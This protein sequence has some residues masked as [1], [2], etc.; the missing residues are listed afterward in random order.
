MAITVKFTNSPIHRFPISPFH[1]F[2]ISQILRFTNSPFSRFTISPF[3]YFTIS[4]ILRFTPSPFHP[5]TVSPLHPFTPSPFSIKYEPKD[6]PYRPQNKITQRCNYLRIHPSFL[7]FPLPLLGIPLSLLAHCRYS[8]S[9]QPIPNA[10][11]LRQQPLGTST[12][13][14]LRLQ[15]RCRNPHVLVK[16]RFSLH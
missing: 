13:N 6:H 3:H 5:F 8:W 15:N 16:W 7:P 11:A 12:S 4:Q 1:H 10:P 14:H 9:N 2:T